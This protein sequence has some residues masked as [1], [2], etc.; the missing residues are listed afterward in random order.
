MIKTYGNNI[1]IVMYHY[2]KNIKKSEFPN[3][4]GLEF[5]DFKKQIIFFKKNFNILSNDQF[6]NIIETQKIPKKKS[7]LLTFDDGYK[8]H[9]DYV[10]PYLKKQNILANFYP[11]IICIKNKKILDV[12]KIHFI[13]EKEQNRDKILNL[14]FLY[15]KKFLNKN[16]EQL[17]LDKINLKSRYD[18]KKTILIKKLLQN[19]LPSS[20]REKIVNK[21]FKDIM[22]TSEEDF[23]KKIYMSKSNIQELYANNFTIGSH[24]VDHLWWDKLSGKKQEIEIKNS[25]NYFKKIRVFDKNFSVCYPYGRYNKKTLGLLKRYKVKFALTT[26]VDK[27]NLKNINNNL[28]LPRYNTNDFK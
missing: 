6:S 4:K 8:D 19:H 23:S 13:L 11:P 22:N 20:C 28:E 10:F 7:I 14:I 26:K 3:Q 21:I 17:K 5:N 1:Y 18:D 16:L 2:V 9:L 15:L 27:V 25:I 24:G 12:N